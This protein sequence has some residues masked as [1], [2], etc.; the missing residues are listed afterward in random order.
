MNNPIY[1]KF[2]SSLYLNYALSIIFILVTK[3]CY[4]HYNSIT[5]DQAKGHCTLNLNL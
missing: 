4:I 1:K 2:G 3:I 5:K